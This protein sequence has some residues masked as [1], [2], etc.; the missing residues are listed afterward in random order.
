MALS[1][2]R[3]NMSTLEAELGFYLAK[4]LPARP[5]APYTEAEVWAA[6]DRCVLAIEG[7]C[8]T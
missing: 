7:E 5:G 8:A 1:I 6:T 4:D 2:E 3:E